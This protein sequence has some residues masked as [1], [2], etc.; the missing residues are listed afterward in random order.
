MIFFQITVNILKLCDT[1]KFIFN[2]FKTS[3]SNNILLVQYMLLFDF[4]V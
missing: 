4:Y 1:S 2:V 3:G